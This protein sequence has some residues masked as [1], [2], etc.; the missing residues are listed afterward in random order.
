MNDF[1]IKSLSNISAAFKHVIDM[2]KLIECNIY[3]LPYVRFYL[4]LSQL[5]A[6]SSWEK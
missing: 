5:T 2:E 1:D 4:K 3:R 6:Y